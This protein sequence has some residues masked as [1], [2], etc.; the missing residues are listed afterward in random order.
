ML[1]KRQTIDIGRQLTSGRDTLQYEPAMHNARHHTPLIP[2][3]GLA[4]LLIAGVAILNLWL[5]VN[6]YESTARSSSTLSAIQY[7]LLVT[8]D[9]EQQ[10]FFSKSSI[11]K[12]DAE[13]FGRVAVSYTHLTLPTTERV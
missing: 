12:E 10:P 5:L 4:I 3:A 13:Q 6:L 7:G 8:R 9:L 11:G 1:V 2:I